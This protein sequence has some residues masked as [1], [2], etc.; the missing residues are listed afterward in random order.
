M[1]SLFIEINNEKE[2]NVVIGCIYNP[3]GN[4][5]RKFTDYMSDTLNFLGQ[6]YVH[7]CG[8]FNINLLNYEIY[9]QSNNFVDVLA[10]EGFQSLITHPT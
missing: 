8:D 3:P 9:N 2:K 6:K 1:E 7:V 4:D 10:S 5:A